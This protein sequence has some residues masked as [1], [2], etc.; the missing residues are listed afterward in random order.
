MSQSGT[1]ILIMAIAVLAPLLA[2]AISRLLPVPL[3]IFEIVLGILVG[4]DVL[5]WAGDGQVYDRTGGLI[6]AA[7]VILAVVKLTG[8]ATWWVPGPLRRFHQRFGLREAET[9]RPFRGAGLRQYAAPPRG[10]PSHDEPA[11]KNGDG[12]P[13][14]SGG[15]R[16]IR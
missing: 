8:R 7:A 4:P 11:D 9:E 12:S 10:A 15:V 16:A 1:L 2:Y 3:V 6:T 14:E 5:G 13:S